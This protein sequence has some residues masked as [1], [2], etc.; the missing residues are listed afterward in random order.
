MCGYKKSAG[1]LN[2]ANNNMFFRI[3][4]LFFEAYL[5]KTVTSAF[6]KILFWLR[7]MLQEIPDHAL[8]FY[9]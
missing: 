1:N 2:L 9:G 6:V 7:V 5:V 8:A 4:F 3:F